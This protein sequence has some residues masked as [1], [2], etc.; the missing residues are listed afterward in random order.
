MEIN[1]TRL[2]QDLYAMY[3]SGKNPGEALETLIRRGITIFDLEDIENKWNH[4]AIMD[5]H[6]LGRSFRIPWRT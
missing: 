3:Q 6:R 5:E 4:F 2:T 1:R